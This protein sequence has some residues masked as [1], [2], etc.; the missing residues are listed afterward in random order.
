MP[1]LSI[2]GAKLARCGTLRPAPQPSASAS[3]PNSVNHSESGHSAGQGRAVHG[4]PAA[5]HSDTA[6]IPAD[7]P[8]LPSSISGGVPNSSANGSI[9]STRCASP[10]QAQ[11]AHANNNQNRQAVTDILAMSPSRITR[12]QIQLVEASLPMFDNLVSP[13]LMSRANTAADIC[14]PMM[15]SWMSKCADGALGRDPSAERMCLQV[16]KTFGACSHGLDG[17]L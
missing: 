9:I 15:H 5:S 10:M 12:P 14:P 2:P 3:S 4:A 1:C 6:S 13:N 8:V 17:S 16:R 7:R 11:E